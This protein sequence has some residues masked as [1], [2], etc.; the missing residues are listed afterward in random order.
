MRLHGPASEG[1]VSRLLKR[2]LPPAGSAWY[3]LLGLLLLPL[4]GCAGKPG[5]E[6]LG[7]WRYKTGFDPAYL[8][9][10]GTTHTWGTLTLPAVLSDRT[11][12]KGYVGEVTLQREI[13]QSLLPADSRQGFAINTSRISDVAT[14][15]VNGYQAGQ[16]GSKNPYRSA[17]GVR[18]ILMVPAEHLRP[19]HNTLTIVLY[20]N[21]T[22]P[23]FVGEDLALGQP[24]ALYETAALEALEVAMFL[25]FF[26]GAGG[27][28]LLLAFHRPKERAHLYFGTAVLLVSS[29]WFFKEFCRQ[30]GL[31]E[32]DPIF[33][34]YNL[35][36]ISLYFCVPPFLLF[37]AAITEQKGAWERA[38]HWAAWGLVAV[39]VLLSVLTPIV[40]YAGKR[41]LLL[42]WQMCALPGIA[43]SLIFAARSVVRGSTHSRLLFGSTLLLGLAAIRDIAIALRF[44]GPPLLLPGH[45]PRYGVLAMVFS[46]AAILARRFSIAQNRVEDL[47]ADLAALNQELEDRVRVRT[48]QLQ[49]SLAEA[50]AHSRTEAEV[51]KL[52]EAISERAVQRL[53]VQGRELLYSS[54]TMGALVTLVQQIAAGSHPALILGETGTGKELIARMIHER[55]RR[56]EPFIAVN[57][58]ALPSSLW[59]GEIFGHVR[60]AFTDARAA[61]RGR[62]EEAGNGTIF[63]DEIGE[64]PL[65]M[66]SKMLRLVQ[67]LEFSPLGSSENKKAFCRFVFATNRDLER[68]IGLG[69]FREDLY[70]RVSV[71][72]VRLP[73]LRDRREDIAAL[74]EVFLKAYAPEFRK[75]I[76]SIDPDALTALRAYSF[77][78]NIRELQNVIVRAVAVAEGDSLSVSDLNLPTAVQN[79]P[80]LPATLAGEALI[81]GTFQEMLADHARRIIR[82][83]LEQ[84][85]GNRARTAELLG[86]HRSSLD[87]RIKELELERDQTRP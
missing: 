21:G 15:Y 31:F 22:R 78:G 36:L 20:T 81:T 13:P 18:R 42:A 44:I 34:R 48:E 53:V 43:Y 83:A 38:L 17:L 59:E 66:Q 75:D 7:Q 71:F 76:T 65:E 70:Y 39:G 46:A 69:Q 2:L 64:M 27:Y 55:S 73:P 33:L 77:P 57:C 86:L 6:V 28:H 9:P 54:A 5:S 1:K 23:L 51:E 67:E 25:V 32:G 62:V 35:E 49:L 87:Y 8:L 60:G 47:N 74:V 12:F 58:A 61:R 14:F 80:E 10:S 63:F 85:G 19:S 24:H 50:Q 26:L 4:F 56:A 68:M 30:A 84:T 52:T 72:Q 37:F 29:Y 45:L 40:G 82:A 79:A 11:E 41:K 3:L 16:L